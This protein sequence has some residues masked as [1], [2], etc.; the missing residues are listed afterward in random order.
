MGTGE[1][2]KPLA[3]ISIYFG[4]GELGVACYHQRR[5]V[6]GRSTWL[7]RTP[8]MGTRKTKEGSESASSCVLGDGEGWRH[9]VDM[10]L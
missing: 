8:G 1:K 4:L 10:E 2:D 6:P 9:L 5:S 7:S 3:D